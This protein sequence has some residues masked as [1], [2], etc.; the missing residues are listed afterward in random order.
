MIILCVGMQRSASTWQ[1]DV[2]SHLIERHR[3]GRRLGFFQTGQAF[4]HYLRNQGEDASWRV[5][6][7]HQR[8]PCYEELLRAGRARAVY[9]Y[10]DL[11]DVAFSLAHKCACSFEEV[12]EQRGGLQDCLA[13][14]QF[15][16]SQPH[17]LI[18]RY[19]DVIA[20]PV[21]SIEAIAA[22]LDL[23]L[24]AGEAAGL[25]EEYSLRANAWRAVELKQ[26]LLTEGVNLDDPANAHR[27]DERTL[28]HW[29]HIR[30]GGVGGWRELATPRQVA[31]LAGICGAWLKERG[32]ERDDS[33]A[34]PGL[35]ALSQELEAAQTRLEDMRRRLRRADE[36]LVAFK[37]L[38]PVA[39]GVARRLHEW[40][41]R[42]PQLSATVKRFT[43]PDRLRTR[44][45]Q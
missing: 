21:G 18:Q 34:L 43:K 41:E 12:V 11:R 37:R 22:H 2:V 17:T 14:D 24:A 28:L 4:E 40:S 1:Y 27:K 9:S 23:E 38:G 39:L 35:A 6:K 3:D 32:Y 44:S 29:N 31:L 5:M 19:E 45:G 7:T 30:G 42:H 33:W 8:H 16:A 13:D 26:Q 10:R 25:A 15:W 20:N 36:E